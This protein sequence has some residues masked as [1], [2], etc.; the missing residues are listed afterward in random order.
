MRMMKSAAIGLA[1]AFGLALAIAAPSPASAQ[2]IFDKAGSVMKGLGGGG[3]ASALSTA[4]V[5]GGLKDALRVGSETVTGNLGAADG[6]LK[7]PVAHIPLPGWMKSAQSILRFTGQ[8]GLL[9]E[10]EVRMNRAAEGS[11]DEAKAMFGDAIQAMTFE[12]A[13]EILTGPDDSATRYFQGKMTAPLGDKMRPIVER[14]LAATD[15]FALYDRA[16]AAN[17]AAGLAPQGKTLMIDHAVDGALKG[18]FHYI[19]K[20]EAAIR[21]NPA[22][23]VTPLLQKVF[24]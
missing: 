7:D 15:A 24:G 3:S 21:N 19:A 4:E 17:G 18:L 5:A 6:F 11:M 22:K 16:A 12:D 14:E 20:E 2:S 1:A 8:S 9:D 10:I 23:R 13:K